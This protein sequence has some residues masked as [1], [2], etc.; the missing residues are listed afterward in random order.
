[1][2]VYKDPALDP[3]ATDPEDSTENP[4]EFPANDPEAKILGVHWKSGGYFNAVGSEDL[5]TPGITPTI[6]YPYDGGYGGFWTQQADHWI[7]EG[8]GLANGDLFGRTGSPTTSVMGK[9]NDGT[10]F[11]CMADGQTIL[12]PLANSGT[13]AN[14]TILGLAPV[15]LDGDDG[16]A[17]MGIYTLPS[18][19][20]VFSG[21][22]MGWASALSDS[23]NVQLSKITDNVFDKFIHQT[24]PQE[25]AHPDSNYLFYDRFNCD[26]LYHSAGLGGRAWYE[27]IPSHNYF[28]YSGKPEN[29]SY[30]DRCG[31]SDSGLDVT[32]DPTD[33]VRYRIKLNSDWSTTNV[34]YSRLYLNLSYLTMSEND[35]FKIMVHS[36][37]NP[38]A[39]PDT[40]EQTNLQIRK[41]NGPFQ[42][43]YQD[44]V[45]SAETDWVN[46][47]T[48][49]P[50]LVETEWDK[51]NNKLTM[52]VD[53][54]AYSPVDVFDLS[55][56]KSVNRA[57]I[58]VSGLDVGE[59][60]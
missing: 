11:N 8:T 5:P 20:A 16:F 45:A 22:T 3:F 25:P 15:S 37:Y 38:Q 10:F 9:E 4:W 57:D 48:Y 29:I 34:L 30:S 2:V 13:P 26:N 31:I 44:D 6:A 43:R 33:Y 39:D 50:F 52:W 7:F 1:M 24:F 40:I 21:S 18:G 23:S 41:H 55:G 35:R 17:V 56:D 54:T 12:G 28:S 42:I 51:P 32:I 58:R 59:N 46:V 14:F 19:G 49:R 27:G 47:P 60:I 53:G 36:Y